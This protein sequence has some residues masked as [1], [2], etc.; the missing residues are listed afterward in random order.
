MNPVVTGPPNLVNQVNVDKGQ[1]V[2]R[3]WTLK[4]SGEQMIPQNI[5]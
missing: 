4:K 1:H 3:K 2:L 5:K